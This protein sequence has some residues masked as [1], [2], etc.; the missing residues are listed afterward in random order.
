[1]VTER[2]LLVKERLGCSFQ[3][4]E[5]GDY[6]IEERRGSGKEKASQALYHWALKDK[7]PP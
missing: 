6:D 2:S 7:W 1:M 3:W 5:Y 4:F